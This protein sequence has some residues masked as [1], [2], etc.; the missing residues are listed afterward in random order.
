MTLKKFFSLILPF[1]L[2][3]NGAMADNKQEQFDAANKAY[4]AGNYEEAIVKYT[5]LLK[6]GEQSFKVRFNLGNAYYRLGNMPEALLNYE[7]AKKIRP[8]DK[9][10]ENNIGLANNRIADKPSTYP[11]FFLF[12]LWRSM[13]LALSMDQLALSGIIFLFMSSGLFIFYI[14]GT[15]RKQ[16]KI[17]FYTGSLVLCL[18]LFSLFLAVKQS[19]YFRKNHEAIASANAV[20]LQSAPSED[21]KEL[22]VIHAGTKVKIQDRERDWVRVVLPNGNGG[23]ALSTS[24]NEI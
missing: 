2:L 12:R 22:F 24:F 20:R 5:E 19:A 10:L 14:F 3:N 9:E 4:I 21:A 1:L 11:E 16:K 6:G 7:K 13:F 23:W 15:T 17:T 18:S 8:S